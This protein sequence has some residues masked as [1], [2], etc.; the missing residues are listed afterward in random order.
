MANLERMI[1]RELIEERAEENYNLAISP[2]YRETLRQMID[3]ITESDS[4]LDER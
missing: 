2:E 1:R 4:A 3:E